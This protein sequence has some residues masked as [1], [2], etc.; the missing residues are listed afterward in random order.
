M[1]LFISASFFFFA[2]LLFLLRAI[3]IEKAIAKRSNNTIRDKSPITIIMQQS[4]EIARE[5]ID[6]IFLL[7]E[8]K[9]I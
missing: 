6:N 5:N 7:F 9:A 3:T 1:L 4:K 2:S 8:E